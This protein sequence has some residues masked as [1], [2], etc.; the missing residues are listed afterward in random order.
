ME[1]RVQ[2][3]L[4][5]PADNLLRDPVATVGMPNGRVPP[6]AFG[7]VHPPAQVEEDSFPRTGVPELVEIVREINLE[8]C[9]RLPVYAKPLLGWP[10]LS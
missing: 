3:R 1:Q 7:N 9:N 2:A 4:Q 5:I 8:V 6:V 10:S